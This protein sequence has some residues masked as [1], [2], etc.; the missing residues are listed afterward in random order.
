MGQSPKQKGTAKLASGSGCT[1]LWHLQEEED[2]EGF[3][4]SYR[5]SW[6][7]G[8]AEREEESPLGLC[9]V[10]VVADVRRL[11]LADGSGY[12]DC[13]RA[14]QH[15]SGGLGTPSFTVGNH[16]DPAPPAARSSSSSLTS[17]WSFTLDE[18][19]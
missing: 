18:K 10:A 17:V 19:D 8:P 4:A 12:R 14:G 13:C 16:G 2:P 6:L 3:A 1:E 7:R 9:A 5:Q 11:P 15:L